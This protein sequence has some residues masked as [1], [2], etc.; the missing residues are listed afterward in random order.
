MK[1]KILHLLMASLFLLSTAIAKADITV[2]LYLS[3]YTSG[4]LPCLYVWT[5]PN[6]TEIHPNGD[7]PG[8]QLTENDADTDTYPGVKYYKKTFPYNSINFIVNKGNNQPQSGNKENITSDVFF[9]YDYSD[10]KTLNEITDPSNPSG[11]IET[12]KVKVYYDN[13]VTKW[14]PVNFYGFDGI[15][16]DTWSGSLMKLEGNNIYSVEVEQF[17]TG[18]G[19]FNNGQN[20][21]QNQT[22]DVKNIKPNYVYKATGSTGGKWSWTEVG[23]FDESMLKEEKP[24][25]PASL[26]VIGQLSI[27]EWKTN[28]GYELTKSGT[29]NVF[30]G[31]ITLTGSGFSFCTQLGSGENDWSGLGTRF[32]PADDI[33]I[34]PGTQYDF[35]TSS[36]GDKCWNVADFTRAAKYNVTVDWD[37]LKFKVEFVEFTVAPELELSGNLYIIGTLVEGGWTMEDPGTGLKM[38]GSNGKFTAKNVAIQTAYESALAFFRFADGVGADWSAQDGYNVFGAAAKD[39]PAKVG[40]SNEITL[41]QANWSK[42]GDNGWS[43]EPGTYDF[44][45]DITG[46]PDNM[47]FIVTPSVLKPEALYIIGSNINGKEVTT[48]GDENK[49][50]EQDGIYSIELDQLGTDKFK[51]TDGADYNFG[52]NGQKLTLNEPYTAST[53]SSAD[54]I[55]IDNDGAYL[56]NANV[57]LDLAAGTVTVTGTTTIDVLGVETVVTVVDIFDLAGRAVATSVQEGVL[58]TLKPGVYVVRNGNEVKK[59]LVK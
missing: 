6:G 1:N 3:N 15:T 8:A 43:I 36:L 53:D 19:V 10:G 47:T 32:Q 7:W 22:D 37:N 50:T 27:G 28:Q 26:Y 29:G 55:A 13:S 30:T 24:N 59:L 17:T 51:I 35:P 5:S 2:H 58:N 41:Y 49:M 9:N 42:V 33:D 12:P 45:V 21:D 44:E 4:A 31:E 20:G 40:E 16:T 34:T 23:E 18:S 39:T 46:A 52:S 56:T 38:E 57:K 54:H 14:N 48:T 25:A 11:V